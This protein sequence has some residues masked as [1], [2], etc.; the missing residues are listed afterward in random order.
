M[1]STFPEI[2]SL[3]TLCTAGCS[4]C[5]YADSNLQK[6]FLSPSIVSQIANNSSQKLIILT[7][8]EPM[9]HPKISEVL[10]GFSDSSIPFRVATGGF[11]DLRPWVHQ[12]K[13]LKRKGIL[14]GISVGTDVISQRV[15]SSKWV[16]IW[17]SNILLL[18]E[19]KI[20]YSLTMTIDSEFKFTWF[21]VWSWKGF[22][23]SNPDFI[24]L[25]YSDPNDR[26]FWIKKIEKRFECVPVVTDNLNHLNP[27]SL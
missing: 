24:Y 13:D 22:Q 18:Q 21:D 5:P 17:K 27:D 7:G 9:L 10:E 20:P 16:N 11:V 12:F 23:C 1:T 8:G 4:H 26:K 14:Q 3:T 19:N 15:S 25:R 6:L 2:I